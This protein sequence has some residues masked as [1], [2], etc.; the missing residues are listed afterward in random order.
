MKINSIRFKVSV[1]F[2]GFLLLIL[3]VFSMYEFYTIRQTLYDEIKDDLVLKVKHIDNFIDA[4]GIVSQMESSSASIMNRLFNSNE[5]TDY[6]KKVIDQ[7]WMKDSQSMGLQK[8]YYRILSLDGKVILN[9]INMTDEIQKALSVQFPALTTQTSFKNLS[10]NG[11]HYYGTNYLI[12]FGEH[13]PLILQLVTSLSSLEKILAKQFDSM[14]SG[15][16]LILLLTIF[17]GTWLTRRILKPV[18]DVTKTAN[19]ISQVNLSQRILVK[20]LDQ[21]MELLVG[22]FNN[23][24]DR[25]ERSFAYVNEFNS[26]IAHELKTPLAIMKGEFEL[27]IG[28]TNSKEENQR[29]MRDSLDEVNRLIKLIKDLLLLAK[30]EYKASIFKME[31]MNFNDFLEDIYQHSK[32]LIVGRNISLQLAPFNQ[33]IHIKGDSVHLRRVF[34]NLIHNAIKFT[35]DGGQV[36]IFS[37]VVKQKVFVSVEDTGIG[38]PLDQQSRIFE[39]FFRIRQ[40]TQE[41]T[42]SNGLG[43][44]MARA[45]VRAHG[46][47]ITFESEVNKG[48]IFTVDLPLIVV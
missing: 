19:E 38:I 7:L 12:S 3:A 44:S 48:S 20:E 14:I 41:E 13:N 9:S 24:I 18:T 8:D 11:A 5:V 4:Y 26:H 6:E 21:E 16:A 28:S 47:D 2:S 43:L 17:M 37:K 36:K 40:I 35:P 33:L 15:I 29:V 42:E 45:I 23:M 46:G 27:A 30:F 25:L 22:S 31:E 1:L 10:I 39:K 34:I 32:I